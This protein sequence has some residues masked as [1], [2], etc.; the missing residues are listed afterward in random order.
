MPLLRLRDDTPGAQWCPSPAA[1]RAAPPWTPA[2]TPALREERCTTSSSP[3]CKRSKTSSSLDPDDS[4]AQNPDFHKET[5][6][7]TDSRACRRDRRGSGGAPQQ[8]G[9][10]D[11][12]GSRGYR[13]MHLHRGA[14]S[15]SAMPVRHHPGVDGA[16]IRCPPR[17]LP[18]L[19]SESP[20]C[21]CEG[22]YQ[23]RPG[24]RTW[25]AQLAQCCP[26]PGPPG[27]RG[28]FGLHRIDRGFRHSAASGFVRAMVP[29]DPQDFPK[30]GLASYTIYEI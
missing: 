27:L 26:T 2:R 22:L 5:S 8:G 28:S 1:C 30:L 13:R 4:P 9:G 19:G 7:T 24:S 23:A 3:L 14:T 21:R 16:S 6:G 11:A 20:R 10:S 12:S 25:G 17:H 15:A 29:G 18:V